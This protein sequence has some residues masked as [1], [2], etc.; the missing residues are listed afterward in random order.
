MRFRDLWDRLIGDES[1]VTALEYALIA[2]LIFLVIVASVQLMSGNVTDL[3]N[4]IANA[5]SDNM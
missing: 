1:G 4:T 5:V 3:Y 2:S